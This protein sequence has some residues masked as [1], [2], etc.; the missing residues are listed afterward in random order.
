MRYFLLILLLLSFCHNVWAQNI[1]LKSNF[2]Q[3]IASD[4]ISTCV[5]NNSDNHLLIENLGLQKKFET[6]NWIYFSVSKNQLMNPDFKKLKDKIYVSNTPGSILSDTAII[7]HRVNLVH[8]GLGALDTSY[9]GKGVIVGV[10]DEGLDYNH[11][12]FKFANGNTRVLR[13]WDQNPDPNTTGASTYQHYGYGLVWDSSQINSGVCTSLESSTQHGTTVTGMAVG[14]GLANG[15]NIGVAPEADIIVVQS[16]LNAQNWSLTVAD[17]C[18]YIF[19]VAD[20][21]NKPAVINISMGSYLGSHDA[22]DPAGEYIDS[23]LNEKEGRIVVCA[24]GNSGAQGKYHVSA[25]ITTDTSFVWFLNNPNSSP[26]GPNSIIFDLW[27]DTSDANFYFGFGADDAATNYSY[28]GESSFHYALDNAFQPSVP[29]IF[30]TIF[31]N[32]G[33]I[34]ALLQ[35]YREIEGPNLHMQSVYW[36]DS[37]SY[38]YRFMTT[39]SGKYDIW[40]GSWQGFGDMEDSIPNAS[41][42]PSIINY[43]M[44][45]SLQSI[46]SS[47]NCSDKVVSVGNIRNRLGHIDNNNNQYYPLDMTQP[48]YL[49]PNSSKGPSRQGTVKP[50]V[51][52]S[53]DVSLTAGPLSFL[54]NPANNTAIDSNGWHVRNGGTSMASPLVAGLAALYLQKC[55][56]ANYQDFLDAIQ[57]SSHTDA[58]TGSVPNFAFG[59]GKVDALDLFYH[60]NTPLILSPGGICYGDSVILSLDT[61]FN[62]QNALWSTGS[63]LDS[64]NVL[65]TGTY[66]VFTNDV[67]GCKSFD[68]TYLIEYTLPFVDAGANTT[69]C[70]GSDKIFTGIGTASTYQWSNNINDGDTVVILSPQMYYLTG[71]NLYGCSAIDSIYIDTFP[72]LIVSYDELNILVDL[73]SPSFNLTNGIPTGGIYSGTGV[74]GTTFHPSISGMGVHTITYSLMDINGCSSSDTSFIEVTDTLNLNANNFNP[75]VVFPNPSNQIIN[76]DFNEPCL[77]KLFSSEGKLVLKKGITGKSTI[78]IS[79]LSN[80]IYMLEF[81]S[82]SKSGKIKLIIN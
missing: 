3:S 10:I 37:L 21:L 57:M 68:S 43:H 62:V 71:T 49:S 46:V 23:L 13:Y 52:A 44:P 73:T 47:W 33:Q 25:N 81:N 19:K 76:I 69:L 74:I 36:V 39:G 82:T 70:I 26:A 34:L 14:N 66:Y 12:D 59:Y 11:P 41:V 4:V 56:T 63:T 79:K 30:D 58:I 78:D 28:R 65:D 51:S 60:N 18:D 64:I 29:V 67:S 72:E 40:A 77:I 35:T 1:F 54:S 31:N 20:S 32:N 45:D 50:N 48:G 15:Q 53:G 27:T 24:A 5:K 2:D 7:R 75:F 8:Q 38:L 9:T 16:Y 6:K 42:M 61:S 17:A 55:A 22:K 80:G